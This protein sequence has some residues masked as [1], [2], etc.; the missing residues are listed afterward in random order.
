MDDLPYAELA[1]WTVGA[2]LSG[3]SEQDTL[4]GFCERAIAIGVPL[5]SAV[6]FIDTLHPIHEGQGARWSRDGEAAL[7]SYGRTDEGVAA[8]TWRRSPFYRLLETGEPIIHLRLTEQVTAEFPSLEAARTA[9]NTDYIAARTGFGADG[10]I[11]VMDCAYSAWMTDRPEGFSER[12]I[13]LLQRLLPYAAIAL[14]CSSL[15]RVAETL[16]TT[17]LGRDAGQ[18]VLSGRIARGVAD[19]IDAVLWFSD[20]RD[21]TRI[22]DQAPPEHI[23]PL[24][25]DYAEAVVTAI[26]QHGGDVLKLIGDGILALFRAEDRDRACLAAIGAA[27]TAE[28]NIAALNERRSAKGLPISQMYLGLHSGEVFFGNVGSKERLD[29]TVV[30]PAVNEVSRIAAMCRSADQTL[31]MSQTFAAALG[32]AGPRLASVGRYALRGVSHAQ[33]LF[34]IEHDEA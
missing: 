10:V 12:H 30:G 15:G 11:R 17:Y 8:E 3:L 22:T 24:L 20:L 33:E 19:R 21:Y 32:G 18:L 4:A 2:G 1:A 14:K 16:V 31:L 27:K 29:F 26:E 5:T 23:L 9:G 25:N 6:M 34:T 13:K 7:I 28:G